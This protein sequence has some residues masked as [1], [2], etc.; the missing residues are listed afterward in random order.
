[1]R[2][3]ARVTGLREIE[4]A[5]NDLSRATARNTLRRVG[6]EVLEPMANIAASLAP[7]R[8]GRLAFSVAVSEKGTRRA[9][10][11]QRAAAF[12]FVMAM[13]PASGVGALNY[14][15]FA[16]FGTVDTPAFGF[17]RATW[18]RDKEAAMRRA[19]ESLSVEVSAA[20]ARASR[21]AARRAS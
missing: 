1:M 16:E 20:T 13:G 19:V 7:E 3:T 21:R 8:S 18:D 12:D 11:K 9:Q 17:M 4:Q 6:R 15:S 2:V 5:L 10:W 14:A